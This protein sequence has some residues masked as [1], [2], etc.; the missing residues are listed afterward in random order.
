[1]NWTKYA[2]CFLLG[3]MLMAL[4]SQEMA[5]AFFPQ[6]PNTGSPF[7]ARAAGQGQ[8][9]SPI[10]GCTSCR[11]STVWGYR[12]RYQRHHYGHDIA[13]PTGTPI[14]ATSPGQV[15]QASNSSTYGLWVE[16]ASNN[17]VVLAS[18][19]AY[20]PQQDIR[21]RYAHLSR[22]A[23]SLGEQVQVGQVLGYCGNTGRS[24]GSHLHYE[25]LIG[26]EKVDPRQFFGSDLL[27]YCP[28]TPDRSDA[29]GVDV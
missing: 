29:P 20:T 21:T 4:T 23:V 15:T 22:I 28:Q 16:V 14:R 8:M 17:N 7:N 11:T 19:G 2:L 6:P 1:M 18:G 13:C 24:H 27:D 26:G 12:A 10:C 3:I 9:M 25:V 5:Q